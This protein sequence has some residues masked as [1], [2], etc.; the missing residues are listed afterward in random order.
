MRLTTTLGACALLALA[1]GGN[2]YA[3]SDADFLKTVI[4]TNLAEISVGQ[5][6]QQKGGTAEVRSF[7]EML[8][9]DHTAANDKAKEL[10]SAAGVT[11][12]AEPSAEQKQLGDKLSNLSGKDFDKQFADAMVKGHGDAIALFQD[13]ADDSTNDVTTFAKDTLPT[14]QKHLAEAEKI[15]SANTAAN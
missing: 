4:Q 3:A 6:A 8:V 9:K 12:P 10:A 1:L 13:K 15:A 7:G 5:L 11:P 14:L 2:A